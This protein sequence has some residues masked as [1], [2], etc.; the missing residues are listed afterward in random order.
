MLLVDPVGA[1][2]L[3]GFEG[4]DRV[5]GLLHRARH[6]PADR[7]PLPSHLLHDLGQRGAVLPLEHGDHLRRLA[8]LARC[9]GFLRFAAVLPLGAFFA[10]VAFLVALAFAG[11]PLAACAPRL[12]V[13]SAFGSAGRCKLGD[14]GQALDALPDAAGGGLG[15][16]EALHRLDARQA[17]P[18]GYQALRRPSLGKFREF[19]LAAEAVERGSGR[20]GGLFCG[21]KRRDVVLLS[22]VKSS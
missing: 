14:R 16:L 18:D 2:A 11:A 10:A 20:G 22:I 4:L 21:A 17:V 3:V 6:E 8:A 13:L 15:G 19:L 1:L 9:G 5:S 12:A 7:V